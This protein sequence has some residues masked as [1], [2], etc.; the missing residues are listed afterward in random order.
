MMSPKFLGFFSMIGGAAA[1]LGNFIPNLN[2][3][4]YLV[5]IGAGLS[6]LIGIAA[7]ASR[8]Y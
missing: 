2:Q 6:V 1:L 4:Y 3:K 8:R 5:P 7:L